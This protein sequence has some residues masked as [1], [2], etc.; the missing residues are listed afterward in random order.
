LGRLFDKHIDNQELNALVPSASET[1][2]ELQ[3]LSPDAIRDAE[4]HVRSCADCGGKMGKYRLLVGR[5]SKVDASEVAPPGIDC[6]GI[7]D[8]DWH[9][10]AAG[11][12]PELKARQLIMHAALCDHCGPLLRAAAPVHDGLTPQKER[13]L[14]EMRVPSRSTPLPVLPPA[15]SWRFMRW[16]VPAA[17]LMVIIGVLSTLQFSSPKSLS[18][19][20]YAEFAVKT[21]RQRAQG[22]LALDV[23]LDSQQALNDWLKKKL[24]FSLTLPSSPTARDEE[25]PYRLEGARLVQVGGKTAAFIAYQM[26]TTQ[27]AMSTASLMVA[28]DSVAIASG[29]TEVDFKKVSFHYA[30]IDGYKVVTWSVHGLT[31]ALVSEEDN[32][33]QRSCMVCHSAMGDRDLS[34]TPTPLRAP[35]SPVETVLQ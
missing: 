31:Y 19:P 13:Q 29:G 28:P 25:R 22:N 21:H 20:K 7:S 1:R 11:L 14:A 26:P 23:R 16:L 35:R 4:R 34:H 24:Q 30:M 12:W 18:G 33:M 2:H 3:G 17:A 9:E 5:F 10:V 32:E 15:L 27:K 8:V 6:P